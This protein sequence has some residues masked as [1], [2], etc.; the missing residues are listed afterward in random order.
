VAGAD[1]RLSVALLEVKGA[2]VGGRPV[3]HR[4]NR[5]GN[6]RLNCVLHIMAF[7]R[8]RD[9]PTT[10]AFAARLRQC[11]KTRRDALRIIKRRLARRVWSTMMQDCARAA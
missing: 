1:V 5:Q 3:H 11:G 8:L 4:L 9:A 6:R 10:Q 7:A 2:E